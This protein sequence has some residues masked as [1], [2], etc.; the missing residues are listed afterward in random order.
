[1]TARIERAYR[2]VAIL[3]LTMLSALFAN[4]AP[5]ASTSP[6]ETTVGRYEIFEL[7]LTTTETFG[8]PFTEARL[9]AEF[10]SPAG[11]RIV[12]PG[13]YYGGTTWMVRFAPDQPGQWSFQARLTGTGAAIK[14]SGSFRCVPSK[15]HGFVRLS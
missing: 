12:V 9:T 8:N 13:F 2:C 11:R 7:P 6:T 14:R 1:M 4:A 10:K 3:G 5:Q 15:H